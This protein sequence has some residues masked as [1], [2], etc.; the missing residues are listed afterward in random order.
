LPDLLPPVPALSGRVKLS[1]RSAGH[2]P[3][4][5]YPDWRKNIPAGE[6]DEAK[7]EGKGKYKKKKF[8]RKYLRVV[9]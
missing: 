5:F 4:L 9:E 2:L 8:G 3:I 7:K 1:L 6:N